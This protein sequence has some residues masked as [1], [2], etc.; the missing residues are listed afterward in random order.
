MIVYHNSR[1]LLDSKTKR[2]QF[3]ENLSQ[4][5]NMLIG[6]NSYTQKSGK[7]EITARV[8]GI[9]RVLRHQIQST[10]TFRASKCKK[11]DRKGLELLG[12]LSFSSIRMFHSF[13]TYVTFQ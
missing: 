2:T 9:S 13:L 7:L 4:V 3:N 5:F 8:T 12:N 11:N 6:I 10:G 1:K